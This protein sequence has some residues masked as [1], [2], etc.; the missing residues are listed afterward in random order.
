MF[1]LNTTLSFTMEES[2]ALSGV[3]RMAALL[4]RVALIRTVIDVKDLEIPVHD[5]GR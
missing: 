3:E 4:L 2:N 1:T 5:P